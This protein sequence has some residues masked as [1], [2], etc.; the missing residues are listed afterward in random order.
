MAIVRA[1]PHSPHTVGLC[2]VGGGAAGFYAAISSAERVATT[3][4][5]I[6]EILI[7]EKSD[8]LLRK[9]SISG[10][11]RCNVTHD[12][13]ALPALIQSSY[14]RGSE[15]MAHLARRHSAAHV[16]QW[17][18]SKGV[19]LKTES[20]GRVFPLSD[21]SETIVDCLVSTAESLGIRMLLG[22]RV[23]ALRKVSVEPP[24]TQFSLEIE[25]ESAQC[26]VLC[27][28]AI[29]CMG[30][31]Q[32]RSVQKLLQDA[33]A[34]VRP[35]APSLFSVLTRSPD[36]AGLQ[37]LSVPDAAIEI[38]G[39][40]LPSLPPI[41]GAVLITH[42]GL[43]GPGILRLSAW[44]AFALKEVGYRAKLRLNW[45]PFLRSPDD[46]AEAILA[47]PSGRENRPPVRRKPLGDVS[48]WPRRLPARL[49]GRLLQK[50]EAEEGSSNFR[51]FVRQY[52]VDGLPLRQWPWAVFGCPE[53]SKLLATTLWNHLTVH[54]VEVQGR[55]LNKEEFVTAGGVDVRELD[56]D[57]M[58]L[59]SHPGLHF[60]GEL[61]DVDGI[62]GGFNFQG[63]WSS[64]HAAGVAA[65]DAL[66]G[67]GLGA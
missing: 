24:F 26:A 16:T 65:A 46:A 56:W 49:W 67:T 43:S 51:P 15:L 31:A 27:R 42:E 34:K 55:R 54:E 6:G 44:G 25:T 18:Q 17:F 47:V 57:R 53:A 30:S 23:C 50:L 38:V 8:S 12:P 52:K 35:V 63:C 20:D 37:G 59:R 45:V 21:K 2:V 64:G 40:H 58:E 48:P 62:T 9:V 33:G 14:P 3:Q 41:R 5:R 60:A 66:Q 7:V 29:L 61:L 19:Q 28:R 10:G 4:R 39:E 36:L 11:G 1:L 22:A 32:K 13:V